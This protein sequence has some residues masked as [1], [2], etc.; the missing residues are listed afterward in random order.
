VLIEELKVWCAGVPGHQLQI[1]ERL[2]VS[3]GLV[4][5]WLNGRRN[6]SVDQFFALKAFLRKQ[7]R[8][9]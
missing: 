3:R 7:R 9:E 2:E 1:A 5:D 8:R 6:P 4:H